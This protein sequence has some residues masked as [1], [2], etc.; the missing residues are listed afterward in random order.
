MTGNIFR[1]HVQDALFNVV[2]V[3]TGQG[4]HLLGM[5]T[6]AIHTPHLQ[7]RWLSIESCKMVFNALRSLKDEISYREDG[8]IR[9]RALKTLAEAVELLEAVKKIGLMEAIAR[10]FFAEIKRR[11]EGGR[12]LDGVVPKAPDYFNP[13]MEVMAGGRNCA[14]S[15][16]IP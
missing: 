15:G 1:G 5:P 4:I 3:L 13:F 6:E 14:V 7:D 8:V 11:P 9:R 2:S 12:G 16:R 10:G